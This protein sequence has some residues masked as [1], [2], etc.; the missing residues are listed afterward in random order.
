MIFD[1]VKLIYGFFVSGKI[2]AGLVA[3]ILSGI[4][5]LL[6]MFFEPQIAVTII[7]GLAICG[8][9]LCLPKLFASFGSV[10]H[11]RS[12]RYRRAVSR[13][14][15][16][17]LKKALDKLGGHRIFITE[18]HNG[19]SSLC[20]LAFLYMD[21]TYLETK[22]PDDWINFEYRNLSVTIYPGFDW[23]A[24]HHTFAG[25]VDKLS[26]IDPRLARIIKSNGTNYLI[27]S[28]MYNAHSECI[29]TVILTFAEE[30]E[31][32][33]SILADFQRVV[34]HIECLID[35]RLSLKEV[36]KMAEEL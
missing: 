12:N 24:K 3:V 33:I 4:G 14:I 23:L 18:G 1:A 8:L 7:V 35:K 22:V 30:P 11:N 28:C 17:D 25:T 29:G 32:P 27:A 15:R 19:T 21:I 36:E 26:T 2:W 5:Y 34:N 9:I 6:F 10:E 31:N 16:N 20:D 13:I